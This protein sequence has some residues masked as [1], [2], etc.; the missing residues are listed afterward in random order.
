[1]VI[2]HNAY[3]SPGSSGSAVLDEKMELVG[4]CIGG[5]TDFLGRFKYGAMIPVDQINTA[6][7]EWNSDN[8]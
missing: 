7:K 6:I 3:V 5:G 1:M 2:R 4:I 8:N